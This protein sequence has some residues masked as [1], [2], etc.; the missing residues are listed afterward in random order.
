MEDK[1]TKIENVKRFSI[2]IETLIG[3]K[4]EIFTFSGPEKASLGLI[5]DAAYRVLDEVSKIIKNKT[6]AFV[7]QQ[8]KSKDVK[9]EQV[10]PVEVVNK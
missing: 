2:N 3:D 4:K 10:E 6:D 7:K 5:Y 1:K 8:K 9:P